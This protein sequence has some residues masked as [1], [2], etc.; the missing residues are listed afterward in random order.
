MKSNDSP[1]IPDRGETSD[2]PSFLGWGGGCCCRL[3]LYHTHPT[4]LSLLC[5]LL[6]LFVFL[7]QFHENNPELR[8]DLKKAAVDLRG[9][10][11]IPQ[12]HHFFVVVVVVVFC[13]SSI[14]T[15]QGFEMTYKGCRRLMWYHSHF[16]TLLLFFTVTVPLEQP[17]ASK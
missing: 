10:I 7:S 6:G 12:H 13:H 1:E 14:G 8:S 3:T 5:F 4:T 15:T 16:T 9:I 11:N 17:R 2:I